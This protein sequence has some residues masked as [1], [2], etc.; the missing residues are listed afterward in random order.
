MKA[1]YGK[2]VRLLFDV[3][4]KERKKEFMQK[5]YLFRRFVP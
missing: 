4:N 1:A 3:T 2:S 5:A